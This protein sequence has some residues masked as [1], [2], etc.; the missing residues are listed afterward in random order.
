MFRTVRTLI[1]LFVLVAVVWWTFTYRIGDSTVAEHLE[2]I[3]DTPEAKGLID[4]AKHRLDPMLDEAK[5]RMIGEYIEAPTAQAPQ[6]RPP[7]PSHVAAGHAYDQSLQQQQYRPPQ[8]PRSATHQPRRVEAPT[9]TVVDPEATPTAPNN[10][11]ATET[12][13]VAPQLRD[14]HETAATTS[15]NTANNTPATEAQPATPQKRE[16]HTNEPAD[17]PVAR[18]HKPTPSTA[19]TARLPGRAG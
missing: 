15:N 1:S 3:G 2:H 8:L 13:P 18:T 12:Q 14:D 16:D 4:G 9:R 6:L 11:P 5:Q 7:T 19:H 10:T 17:T